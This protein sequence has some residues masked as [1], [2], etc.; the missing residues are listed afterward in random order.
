MSGVKY[1]AIIVGGGSGSRMQSDIP[2]QFMLLN[3]KPVLMHSIVAFH[4]S[5]LNPEI[6]IV[7]NAG[8][9]DYWKQLCQDHHFTIP[10]Q[11]IDGGEHRFHSVKNG[12]GLVEGNAVVAI[13]DAVRP[14]ISSSLIDSA[15][16]QAE[17]IGSA[18]TAIKSR[19]SVRQKN[20]NG[21]TSLNREDIYLVQTPQVFK[22][23][24]LNKAYTQEFRDDFT[25]DASV[26]ERSGVEIRLIEGETKNIKITFPDDIRIAEIY[27][28]LQ[29]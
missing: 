22:I 3:G 28:D 29:N 7:L 19:D 6:I 14:C 9:H 13:H 12:L 10:H 26:V 16:K 4:S 15:Y 18:V 24:M 27:L 23:D 17:E 2:K 8:F 5:K 11:L 20:L 1:Y 21:S 25:D